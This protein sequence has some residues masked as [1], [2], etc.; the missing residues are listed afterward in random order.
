MRRALRKLESELDQRGIAVKP[1]FW[2]GEEWFSPDGVPGVAIPFYLAH[3]RLERLQRRMMHEVEGGNANWLM[4][5]LRHEAGHAIDT[6]Y[7]LR[8]RARWREAFGPASLPYPDRYRARPGS[9]RYVHHLGGWYAQA[10]PTEDFAETF[11]VWLKPKSAW[12]HNYAGWPALNK[13]QVVDELMREVRDSAP[14]VRSRARIEPVHE[15]SQTLGDFYASRLEARQR[16][17]RSAT[18]DLLLRVFSARE[19]RRDAQRAA[20]FL[21]AA[22]PKL[23]IALTREAGFERYSVFQILRMAIQRADALDL[24]VRGSRR[25]ALRHARWMLTRLLRTYETA[26]SP[27]Q[28]L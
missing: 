23:V 14:R 24:Y 8:R 25:D 1:H 10:H 16:H 22:K 9:R 13:L 11:A 21:R 3:P 7:R 26:P 15:S 20:V 18:D 19:P 4:R 2:F 28:S 17:R 12:R 6:A 27:Q 5:I